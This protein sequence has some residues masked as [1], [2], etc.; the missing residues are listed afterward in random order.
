MV[1]TTEFLDDVRRICVDV[2]TRR[3]AIA[4]RALNAVLVGGFV[5]IVATVLAFR[6]TGSRARSRRRRG[7]DDHRLR[8]A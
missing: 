8:A 2:S 6:W 3:R 7:R 1:D 4:T 5:L